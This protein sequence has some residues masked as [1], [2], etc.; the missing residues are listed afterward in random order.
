MAGVGN[1]ASGIASDLISHWYIDLSIPVVAA[2]IGYVTKLVAIRMMFQPLEFVGIRPYLGWQGIVPR[3]AARMASIAVDTMTRD[4][5]SAQDVLAP[6]RPRPGREGDRE[7]AA[8]GDRGDH[9]RGPRRVPTRAVGGTAGTG[10]AARRGAC[11]GRDAH[12]RPRGARGH[13]VR[14]GRRLRPQTHGDHEPGHRQGA[15]EPHLPAGRPQGVPLHRAIG[16]LVRRDDRAAAVG[17]V[18]A[19]PRAADHARVRADRRLVDGLARAEAD[20]QSEAPDQGV[21]P[22]HPGPVPAPP[23]RGRGRV[24]R[25]HRGRDHHAAQGDRGDPAGADVRPRRRD[26]QPPG[27]GGA[28]PQHR[29]REAAGRPDRRHRPLPADQADDHRQGHGPAARDHG[30]P[31]GLR[32]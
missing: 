7:P 31:R 10:P 17:A 20:L 11:A 22:A 30:V 24:R 14:C 1:I 29:P 2:L 3:R 27:A 25:A 23:H 13:P 6:A 26:G 12:D 5:I 16:H 21:R 32:P 4:L 19:V 15:P 8:R 28:G 9:P 18:A